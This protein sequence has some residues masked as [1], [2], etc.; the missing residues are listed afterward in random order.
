MK[1]T[2]LV[3][4][5]A[6]YI[7]SVTIRVLLNAGYGVIVADNLSRGHRKALPK[8]VKLY[9][10]DLLDPKFL[11]K[12]F[13][14][15]RISAVINFAGMIEAGESMQDPL[16]FFKNN[17][18]GAINLTK[19]MKDHAVKYIVFSSS[20]AVYG[21]PQEIP[22]VEDSRKVPVNY[23]GYTKLYTETILDSAE[24]YGIK[25]IC[26]RY[27]NAAGAAFGVGEA[28][29]PETHLIPIILQ[30][31]LGMR[32]SIKIFGTDYET[33][34]STC[35]R[36][37]IHVLDL[38]EA[39]LLAIK[40]L[41]D[42]KSG[43]FNVGIGKGYSVRQVID[44]CRRITGREI[45]EIEAG[46]REGDPAQLIASS[47]LIRKELG[48]KPNC[49]LQVIISSAWEWHSSHPKGF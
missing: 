37:Y 16:A 25:N 6:G 5:G 8:G 48:W 10:G 7:G 27:F 30:V 44:M 1:E 9:V 45:P 23:Y 3:T 11:N 22:I 15:N 49:D 38:A 24:V 46:R 26:L 18:S 35:I 43:K 29:K 36:D 12:V 2:I 20:A 40:A 47:E 32:K 34:D 21:N 41:F 31:A 19:A 14:R 39:H 42:G 33:P 4:G 17:L 28:H 13:S